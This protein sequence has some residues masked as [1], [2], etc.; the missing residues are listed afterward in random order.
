MF[1]NA[2]K[3]L[4]LVLLGLSA[5]LQIAAAPVDTTA[6]PLAA[7]APLGAAFGRLAGKFG[8][9]GGAAGSA[10]GAGAKKGG[11][12][13]MGGMGLAAAGTLPFMIP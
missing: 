2:S 12:G 5:S 9:K 11:G 13:M 3:F 1:S 8:G 4:L 7:R 6:E 10:A